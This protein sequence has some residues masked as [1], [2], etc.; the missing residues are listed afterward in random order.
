MQQVG[1]GARASMRPRVHCCGW[2]LLHKI[3]G[4][5]LL[6][7]RGMGISQGR[8][9]VGAVVLPLHAVFRGVVELLVV[10]IAGLLQR[11]RN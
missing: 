4:R 9:L 2:R 8:G 10:A 1:S 6:L 3:G 11:R 5:W 7:G